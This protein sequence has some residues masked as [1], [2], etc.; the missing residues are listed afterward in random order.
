MYMYMLNSYRQLALCFGFDLS[1]Y[2][3]FLVIVF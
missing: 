2:K 1:H 3:N